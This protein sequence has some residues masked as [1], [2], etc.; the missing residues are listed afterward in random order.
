MRETSFLLE[1]KQLFISHFHF[2]GRKRYVLFTTAYKSNN[3]QRVRKWNK[4]LFHFR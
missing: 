4:K 2:K 3:K 1:K